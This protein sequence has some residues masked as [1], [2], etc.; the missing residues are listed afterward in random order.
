MLPKI[1]IVTPNYNKGIY[2]E[3]TIKSVLS[4]N[5][6]NLEYI[7]IDGGSTDNSLDIIKKY[8]SQLTYWVSEPDHGMY[9]AISKGFAKATGEIMAWINSDDMYHPMCFFTIAEIFQS[10]PNV[11]WLVGANTAFDKYNRTILAKPSRYFSR[12]DLLSNDYKWIQQESTFWRRSLWEKVHGLNINLKLAGDF[13]LW[14]RFSMHDKMYI[15]D[16]LI[17]GFR[18]LNEGQLTTNIDNYIK[19]IQTIINDHPISPKEKKKIKLLYLKRRINGLFNRINIF[20]TQAIYLWLMKNEKKE[21]D[22]HKITF[23]R[24]AQKFIC[25]DTINHNN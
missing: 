13:D 4:Q 5:Y 1:S 19:E 12:I 11:N 24:K 6:P 15:T 20:N 9:H 3:Y 14:L 2:L 25:N 16:S 7:I 8:E 18:I 23:S 22:S 10:F 17:G 21:Q